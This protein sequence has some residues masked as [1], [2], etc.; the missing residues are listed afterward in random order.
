MYVSSEVISELGIGNC[1]LND[2]DDVDDW[3]WRWYW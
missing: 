1:R 2:D 3:W